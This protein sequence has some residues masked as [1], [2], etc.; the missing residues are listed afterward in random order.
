MLGSRKYFVVDVSQK[1]P[2]TVVR[3]NKTILDRAM[4]GY[5]AADFCKEIHAE[6]YKVVVAHSVDDVALR[7]ARDAFESIDPSLVFELDA[8][9]K[10]DYEDEDQLFAI[11]QDQTKAADE[12][13]SECQNEAVKNAALNVFNNLDIV[14]HESCSKE[15]KLMLRK[16]SQQ[17][18]DALNKYNKSSKMN[19]DEKQQFKTKLDE[20]QKSAEKYKKFSCNLT[21]SIQLFC[22]VIKKVAAGVCIG[23]TLGFS[24]SAKK[25]NESVSKSLSQ[26]FFKWSSGGA[27]KTLVDFCIRAKNI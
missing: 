6:G 26:S 25:F 16:L 7:K 27:E 22:D 24:A 5:S 19:E 12:L 17:I 14:S 10:L 11:L 18:S 20:L 23:A 9:I 3:K 13:V 2:F 15:D 1:E 21:N 8:S 4:V